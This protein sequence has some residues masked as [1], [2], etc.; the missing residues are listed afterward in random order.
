MYTRSR[1]ARASLQLSLWADAVAGSARNLQR[2]REM[3][4][5]YREGAGQSS[6]ALYAA[7]QAERRRRLN[8][9]KTQAIT[10]AIVVGVTVPAWAVVNAVST[11]SAHNGLATVSD[12]TPLGAGPAGDDQ[13]AQMF[14]EAGQSAARM[15]DGRSDAAW[16]RTIS[17]AHQFDLPWATDSSAVPAQPA[18]S[19][20]TKRAA[21]PAEPAAAPDDL[22]DSA[23]VAP[24][25]IDTVPSHETTD[26]APDR[27]VTAPDGDATAPEHAVT[28]PEHPADVPSSV[29]LPS[30]HESVD[31]EGRVH[32][33]KHESRST[34]TTKPGL[35]A[36]P[37]APAAPGDSATAGDPADPT[38]N[39]AD[40]TAGTPAKPSVPTTRTPDKP[41]APTSGSDST[42]TP[43]DST[44]PTVA[45]PAAP[46]VSEPATPSESGG[47]ATMGKATG[48][49]A[50]GHVA[51]SDPA[52]P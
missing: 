44:E 16:A 34:D 12:G 28:E 1:R 13:L 43:A 3:G 48:K 27:D 6:A 5:R 46:A 31:R 37:A 18:P 11:P 47:G 14:S 29:G 19:A 21:L 7:E 8:R 45:D 20:L 4:Y 25:E 2:R 51:R 36:A 39:A 22:P 52:A 50:H 42:T 32:E 23:V 38:H 33:R 40:P 10:A 9:R 26:T 35:P 41:A 24:D 17:A 49:H 30:R 15:S